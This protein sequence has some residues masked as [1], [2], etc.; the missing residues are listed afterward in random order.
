MLHAIIASEAKKRGWE[1]YWLRDFEAIVKPSK[2][3][4]TVNSDTDAFAVAYHL[5]VKVLTD[6]L[7]VL[8]INMPTAD[9]SGSTDANQLAVLDGNAY[10]VYDCQFLPEYSG[11]YGV[12]I[13]ARHTVF[14]SAILEYKQGYY[15]V[16]RYV[17]V[18]K[19]N[20]T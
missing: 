13:S 10:T 3:T 7:D 19:S 12:F 16:L 14:S 5:Q 15:T 18:T 1:N 17:V 9:S 2:T 20:P 4:E 6:Y 11:K 8:P